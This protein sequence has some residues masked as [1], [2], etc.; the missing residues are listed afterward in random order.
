M[1]NLKVSI[2]T[3]SLNAIN[4][5]EQTI[6]SVLNQSYKN[7]EY[8]IIDGQSADGTIDIIKKYEKRLSY[9]VSEPDAGLYDA[10]NK[11][12][13]HA[14]GDIIG[15]INSDDW[16]EP[17]AVE[18]AVRCFMDRDAEL[19]YGR[20][21]IVDRKGNRTIDRKRT[22]DQIWYTTA[23]MH[24]TVFVK[25]DIYKKHGM[26]DL[27]YKIASDYDL[28]LRFYASG[29][30]FEY[31][32]EVISNFRY[33]GISSV[34]YLE[35][36]KE[37]KQISLQY[38]DQ[39]P[40]KAFV[41]NQIERNYNFAVLASMMDHRPETICD[42]LKK[43]FPDIEA[44]SVIFG[45]GL[46]GERLGHTLT[47]G[48]I[49]ILMFVDNNRKIWNTKKDGTIIYNP[50][51]LK[52]YSGYLFIAVKDSYQEICMQLSKTDYARV[53]CITLDE[54]WKVVNSQ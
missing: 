45:T 27:K 32:D 48:K 35:G 24:A 52:G 46:W 5:I 19:V 37:G 28:L 7:I 3:V 26:F 6:L 43:K 50:E 25:H 39:C 12:I 40:N 31:I 29:V 42:A 16:Y 33:G 21:W 22:I 47:A 9:Y 49:P 41:L 2:I 4:T 14:A 13:G 15:I 51:S 54:L 18:K 20:T 53:K 1:N 34:N 44:G 8:I 23:I 36:S 30:R 38:L 11:G 10:M 17:D